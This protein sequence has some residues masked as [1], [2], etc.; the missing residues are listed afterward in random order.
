MKNKNTYL[1]IISIVLAIILFQLSKYNDISIIIT[2]IIY[3]I[4]YSHGIIVSIFERIDEK[5]KNKKN[6]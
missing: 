2:L 6:E 5:L 1:L 3:I 4:G